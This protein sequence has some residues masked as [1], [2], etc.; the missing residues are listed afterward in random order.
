MQ[1]AAE[2]LVMQLLHVSQ[3][4]QVDLGLVGC[5]ISSASACW[6]CSSCDDDME[7]LSPKRSSRWSASSSHATHASPRHA[8]PRVSTFLDGGAEAE[9][10]AWLP[11]EGPG[12]RHVPPEMWAMSATQFHGFL[13]ACKATSVYDELLQRM[14]GKMNMYDVCD[15]FVKPWTTGTGNSVALLLKNQQPLPVELMISHAWAE[16][17]DECAEALMLHFARFNILESTACWFCV[18]SNYQPGDCFTVQ[19]QIALDPF[20]KVLAAINQVGCEE[21][22]EDARRGMV[23]I[24]TSTSEVYERLWCVFEIGKASLEGVPTRAASSYAY[25]VAQTGKSKESLRVLTEN[26]RCSVCE[27]EQRIRE[28]LVSEFG[29]AEM[30]NSTIWE[31]RMAMM[32]QMGYELRSGG[33][34]AVPNMSFFRKGKNA[35]ADLVQL[36]AASLRV[37]SDSAYCK[38]CYPSS[39]NTMDHESNIPKLAART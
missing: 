28:L 25:V 27:D 13:A 38:I 24:H 33:W 26:A 36:Q 7:K 19:E 16:E 14:D 3:P 37:L 32:N 9:R 29:G 5:L 6:E 1:H 20:A 35:A 4:H 30:L 31:F 2:F 15:A 21:G 11:S 10:P 12:N 39:K 23:V 8:S 34:Y 18:F 17:I 22:F